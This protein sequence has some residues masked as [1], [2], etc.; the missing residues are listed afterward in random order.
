MLLDAQITA[1]SARGTRTI[2]ADE[3]V[4]GFLTTT[5]E[6]DELVTVVDVPIPRPEE[7][8]GFQEFAQR[9]GDFALA[10]AAAT[11]SSDPE[12]RI[13]GARIVLFGTADRPIRATEAEAMLEGRPVSEEALSGAARAAADAAVAEDA[14]PDP[15]YRRTLFETMAQRAL[16]DATSRAVVA[17]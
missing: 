10:G 3:L 12:G 15:E 17:R 7:G 13:N 2:S 9:R 16:K 6:E 11:M 5:L 14:R 8:W 4:V 1:V